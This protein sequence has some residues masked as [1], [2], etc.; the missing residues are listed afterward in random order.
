MATDKYKRKH[1]NSTSRY[2]SSS[3]TPVT[4][5]QEQEEGPADARQSS[6]QKPPHS[7]HF[8]CGC[9]THPPGF[10]C[11]RQARPRTASL[12]LHMS[13]WEPAA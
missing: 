4:H 6:G 10:H 5:P 7:I 9:P 2:R 12:G 13:T 11:C 8:V 3:H 1:R